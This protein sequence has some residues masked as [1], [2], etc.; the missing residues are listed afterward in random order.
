MGVLIQPLHAFIYMVF[1]IIA[2][3]IMAVAPVLALL[4]IRYL[5]KS[6][7]VVRSVFRLKDGIITSGMKEA[8]D[9]ITSKVKDVL[10]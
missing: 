2:S 10:Q 7:K 9:Q 8:G 6:E 4:F 5:E 1:M 3:K